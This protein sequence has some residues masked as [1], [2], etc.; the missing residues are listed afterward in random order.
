MIKLFTTALQVFSEERQIYFK[1]KRFKLAESIEE[2]K[3]KKYP[4]YAKAEVMRLEKELKNFDDS[5]A[6]E[7]KSTLGKL[8]EKVGN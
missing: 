4:D 8:I 2:E 1:N 7:F 6:I 3:A 5:F